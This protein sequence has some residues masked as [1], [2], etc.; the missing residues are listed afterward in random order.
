MLALGATI[1]STE[2]GNAESDR[3]A[4]IEETLEIAEVAEISAA[5]FRKVPGSG[6]M[7]NDI[8]ALLR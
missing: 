1:P 7:I 8:V 5:S 6:L 4:L 3:E 2:S